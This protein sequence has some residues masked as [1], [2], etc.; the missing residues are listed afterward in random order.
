MNKITK[1]SIVL[2]LLL[3]A[4][5]AALLTEYFRDERT[6]TVEQWMSFEVNH[7]PRDITYGDTQLYDYINITSHK[8]YSTTCEID[9]KIL[10]NGE[11][12]IDQEGIRVDYSV[13][14]GSG[15]LVTPND[16]NNNGMPEAAVFGMQDADGIY[17][18]RRNI[19]INE[20][21]VP[22]TYKIITKLIPY[23]GNS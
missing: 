20:D 23:Q 14:S 8:Q 5:S 22:G 6:V 21:L 15:A 1:L 16:Y 17:T 3:T 9:T 2:V 18:I 12:L 10:F 13:E 19:F 4:V 7:D 11:E